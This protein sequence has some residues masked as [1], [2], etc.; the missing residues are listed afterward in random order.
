MEELENDLRFGESQR[1]AFRAVLL[2]FMIWHGVFKE[3]EGKDD[4]SEL[5]K[6]MRKD[7]VSLW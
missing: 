5:S 2:D 1:P 3:V 4:C 7:R 6:A